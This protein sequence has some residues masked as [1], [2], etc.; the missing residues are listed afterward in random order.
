MTLSRRIPAPRATGWPPFIDMKSSS[1]P[2]PRSFR[3]GRPGYRRKFLERWH[4]F[5]EIQS[6][7]RTARILETPKT[8]WKTCPCL[9]KSMRSSTWTLGILDMETRSS[10]TI[11]F[12]ITGC[13]SCIHSDFWWEKQCIQFYFKQISLNWKQS[14]R[15][16]ARYVASGYLSHMKARKSCYAN[17]NEYNRGFSR[18]EILQTNPVNSLTIGHADLGRILARPG[19]Y[20][21]LYKTIYSIT[22]VLNI[23]HGRHERWR[24]SRDSSTRVRKTRGGGK[25]RDRER[26]YG[27]H[28][29]A[30]A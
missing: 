28:S 27:V 1:R 22:G 18:V 19:D 11:E 9:C 8:R 17:S 30:R 16:R 21:A 6:R 24:L 12:E 3:C 10:F 20:M 7:G 25:R 14:W 15:S 23:S 13:T 4:S 5:P 2:E 29:L 26:S